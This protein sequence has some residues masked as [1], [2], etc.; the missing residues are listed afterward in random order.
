MDDLIT[1]AT[2]W[3]VFDAD[4]TKMMLDLEGIPSMLDN[5]HVVVLR[6][7]YANAIGGIRLRV[8]KADAE[9]AT[10][11]LRDKPIR[12]DS[13]KHAISDAEYELACPCCGSLDVRYEKFSRCVFFLTWLILGFPII[14]P[15]KRFKC[16]NCRHRWK[17]A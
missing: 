5:R 17:S 13:T 4:F 14:I 16:R 12:P 1:V 10:Q 8:R 2:F 11:L 9:R 6:W 3:D 7:D 15:R